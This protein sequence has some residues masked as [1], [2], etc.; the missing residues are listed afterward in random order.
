MSASLANMAV[1]LTEEP[2]ALRMQRL[3]GGGGGGGGGEAGGRKK[4]K[5][6]DTRHVRRIDFTGGAV[7]WPDLALAFRHVIRVAD[8]PC[9]DLMEELEKMTGQ[10]DEADLED[11]GTEDSD[12]AEISSELFEISRTVVKGETMMVVKP[13]DEFKGFEAWQKLSAKC[14]PKKKARAIRLLAEVC[15]PGQVK[16]STRSRGHCRG[17]GIG[18][19]SWKGSSTRS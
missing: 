2:F 11:E 15:S 18:S 8:R 14:I 10:V 4:R 16:T 19:R 17:G 13:C 7:D 9:F 6:L 3:A 5:R 1:A 12:A